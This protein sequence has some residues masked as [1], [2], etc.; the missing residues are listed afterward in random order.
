MNPTNFIKHLSKNHVW[1]T[2]IELIAVMA[3]MGLGIWAL[4]QTLGWGIYYAKDTEDNIKAINIAREWIEWMINIRD[5]NWLRFSSDKT[6]CWKVKNYQ[7]TCIWDISGSSALGS[8]SYI[9]NSRNG[10]WFLSGTTT[11]DPA[12]SWSTYKP[13]YKVWLDANGFYTQTGII[14]TP[15]SS[16][17]QKNCQTIFTR[18]II[19]N[20]PTNSGSLS[21][22]SVVRWVSKR[23]QSVILNTTITNWKSN[24]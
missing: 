24:F 7:S 17:L 9:L 6:N 3:I 22:S 2:M 21:V 10:V 16:T 5:T 20:N 4:L 1:A 23:P 14:L 12:T 15:C 11:I 19:I 18:E 8:W 13:I